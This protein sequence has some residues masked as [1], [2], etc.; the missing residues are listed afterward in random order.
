MPAGQQ[1][2]TNVPQTFLTSQINPTATVLSVTSSS[3]WPTTPFTAVLD[4]GTSSQE[5]VDVTSVVGTTWT[6][7]RA[8]DGTVGFTHQAGATVTHSDIGRDFREARSHIDASTAVHGLGGGSAVV[9]T[10]DVQTLTNKT[11]TSPTIQGSGTVFN[12]NIAGSSNLQVQTLTVVGQGGSAN[13]VD[14]KF[15][16]SSVGPLSSGTNATGDIV[17]DINGNQWYCTSGGA[18]GTWVPVNGMARI[19]SSTLSGTA[20]SVV[21]TMPTGVSFNFVK[22]FWRARGD[23]A[24]GVEE[25]RLRMNGDTGANYLG[26]KMES[27]NASQSSTGPTSATSLQMG[28]MTAGSATANYFSAGEITVSGLSDATRFPQAVGISGASNTNADTWNGRFTGQHLASGAT[29][30]LTVFPNSGNFTAGSVFTCL[31]YV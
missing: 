12:G 23:A 16:N 25:F 18:P 27:N 19:A 5:P 8:I 21:F 26:E 31:G 6:V 13:N 24:S 28:T 3:G 10:T 30:S 29:T 7:T 11:L 20:A 4:I 14:I 22:I 2:A 15:I 17:Y 9:G 1:Y